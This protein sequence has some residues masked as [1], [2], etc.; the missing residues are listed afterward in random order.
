M[1]CTVNN[2]PAICEKGITMK[3]LL[4]ICLLATAGVV[5]ASEE[6]LIEN[7]EMVTQLNIIQ[8][9]LDKVST[10]VMSCMDSGNEHSVCMCQ[11]KAIITQF[12]DGVK[13]FI[14]NN[15]N[16]ESHDL[17]RFKSP[18]GTWITLSIKGLL[19]QANA[20]TPSCS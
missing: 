15:K 7:T 1:Y 4:L 8:S 6:L 14:E 19:R 10:E 18:D 11:N 17:V 20:G 13:V 3:R 5:S 12:N 9:S 16:L 2:N